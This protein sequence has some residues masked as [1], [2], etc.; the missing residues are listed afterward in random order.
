MNIAIYG[1]SFD[2]PHK[3]HE[4]VVSQALKTLSIDKLFIIPAWQ[5]PFKK[6][7]FAPPQTRLK[8]LKKLWGKNK[9][10]K[11]CP[12]EINVGK[13]SP[14]YKT[15]KYL[16]KKYSIDKC[17]LIIGA[18]NLKDLPKWHKYKKLSKKVQFV[19]ASREG[20]TMEEHLVKLNVDVDISS[21]SLREKMQKKYIPK[22]IRKSVLT[23]YKTKLC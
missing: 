21:S 9:K 17:Y 20:F 8:W 19:V 18:D 12:Y 23:F 15:V 5:N 13:A 6:N 2:P 16:Y 10:I 4:E 1:G 3:G 14:T 11:I 7:F 22:A